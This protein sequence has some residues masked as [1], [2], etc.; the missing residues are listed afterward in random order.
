MN[1][2]TTLAQHLVSIMKNYK[3]L[4]RLNKQGYIQNPCMI[5]ECL[6]SMVKPDEIFNSG[7]HIKNMNGAFEL[8]FSS[9]NLAK[10]NSTVIV[11]EEFTKKVKLNLGLSD[12]IISTGHEHIPLCNLSEEDLFRFHL[13]KTDAEVFF[14]DMYNEYYKL[15]NEPFMLIMIDYTRLVISKIELFS[16]E[17]FKFVNSW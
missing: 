11:R 5:G 2:C 4:E 3:K 7:A 8:D 16:T 14:I 1:T 6:I 17:L 9:T 15:S 13:T 12:G 10:L